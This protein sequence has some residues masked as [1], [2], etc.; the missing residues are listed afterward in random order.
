MFQV[1][2]NPLIKGHGANSGLPRTSL[3]TASRLRPK[4]GQSPLRHAGRIM[5]RHRIILRHGMGL[6]RRR[7]GHRVVDGGRVRRAVGMDGGTV[8]DLPPG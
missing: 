6:V 1:K 2:T 7:L 3:T 4:D 8:H 5:V